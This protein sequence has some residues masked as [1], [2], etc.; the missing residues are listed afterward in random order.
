M[1]AKTLPL[2]F[3]A[4][5]VLLLVIVAV[6]L[7]AAGSNGETAPDG[8][9]R[10]RPEATDCVDTTGDYLPGEGVAIGEPNPA[11]PGGVEVPGMGMCARDV[12]DCNDM[13]LGISWNPIEVTPGIEG[14]TTHPVGELVDTSGTD[15]TIGFWMG[16]ESCYAVNAVDVTETDT[17]VTVEISVVTRPGVD[18]CIDIAEARSVTVSLAAPLGDRKLVV[19]DSP[20]GR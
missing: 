12:P 9:T 3:G 17:T 13:D 15:V 2:R 6:A 14:D 16:T 5:L 11:A 4:A 1:N 7:S 10:C 19:G 18:A 20:A 8:A